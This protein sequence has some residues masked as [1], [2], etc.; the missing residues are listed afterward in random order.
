MVLEKIWLSGFI[1]LLWLRVVAF[2]SLGQLSWP[3]API[4][5]FIPKKYNSNVRFGVGF[6][7][8]LFISLFLAFFYWQGVESGIFTYYNFGSS[9]LFSFLLWL[10]TILFVFPFVGLGIFGFKIG[11]WLWLE[12]LGS[13]LIFGIIF[14]LLIS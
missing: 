12:S 9:L 4:E 8:W 2:T 10:I 5:F 13:W 11:R 1:M 3:F 14:G 7:L 6:I